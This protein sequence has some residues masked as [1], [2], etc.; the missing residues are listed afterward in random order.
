MPILGHRC[1]D[2]VNLRFYVRVAEDGT[3]RR[4]VVFVRKLVPRRAIAAVARWLYNE[5]YRRAHGARD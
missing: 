4:A 3:L 5:P 1:F 2:E